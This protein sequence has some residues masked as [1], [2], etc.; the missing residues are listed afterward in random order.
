M[1]RK[2]LKEHIFE[3]IIDKFNILEK[4]VD[5]EEKLGSLKLGVAE[6]MREMI[7]IDADKTMKLIEDWFDDSYAHRLILTELKD[8]PFERYKFLDNYLDFNEV[9]ISLT[10]EKSM[11]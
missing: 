9:N 3:W 10:I 5:G 7:D 6:R 1:E 2:E 4:R 11:S 8:H